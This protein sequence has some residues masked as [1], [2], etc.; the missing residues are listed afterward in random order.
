MAIFRIHRMKDAPRQQF[1]FAPHVSG[2]ATVK[3]RDYEAAGEV[4][5]QNEYD[6]WARLRQGEHPLAIG[7]LLETATGELRIFKYVGFEAAQWHVPL[8]ATTSADSNN[9][10]PQ[11]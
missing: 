5:A 3:P 9:S 7:D 11:A 10:Q 1:R 8:P 4:E 6:A 2:A